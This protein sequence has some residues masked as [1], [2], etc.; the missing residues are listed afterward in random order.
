MRATDVTH[1]QRAAREGGE[2]ARSKRKKLGWLGELRFVKGMNM[3]HGDGGH[4]RGLL[5]S[6]SGFAGI[7]RGEGVI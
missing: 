5:A 1:V 2:G 3:C 4:P 7:S 6:A